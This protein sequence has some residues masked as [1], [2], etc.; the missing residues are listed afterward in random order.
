MSI[1][2]F[3][4]IDACGKT[5]QI[6]LLKKYLERNAKV[7]VFSFPNYETETGKAVKKLLKADDCDPLVLQSLMSMNRY[8]CQTEMKVAKYEGFVLLDRY[9]LSGFVYGR[10]D[11]LSESWLREVHTR[12]LQPDRWII[13]DL[14][15]EESFRRRPVR[16]DAYE[17][18]VDRL[19]K[20]RGW[21]ASAGPQRNVSI[22]NAM[23]DEEIIQDDILKACGL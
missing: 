21:Y 1:I 19:E 13:L 14:P 17:A 22:I 9:W 10:A 11:G 16:D 12:L 20:A 5:T 8:E 15:V 6:A 2:A 18:N 3:E 4:G 23:Q 7:R